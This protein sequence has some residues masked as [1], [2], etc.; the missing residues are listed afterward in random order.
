MKLNLIALAGLVGLSS[1]GRVHRASMKRV[2]FGEQLKH[3]DMEQYVHNV[4]QKYIAA[5]NRMMADQEMSMQSNGGINDLSGGHALPIENFL[6]AQYYSEISIG[7]PPQTFKVV[8]DTGSA[9]LWVPSKK[10]NSIACYLHSTYD[11][12]ASSTH[13]KNETEFKIEYGS[14]ALS[15]F[16]SQDTVRLGDVEI[17]KQ[18]FAE[19]VSEPGLAFAFGRFDGILGLAYDTISVNKIVPPFYH[20]VN[21]KLVDEPVFSFYLADKD[22]EGSGSEVVFGGVDES[23]YSG[24]LIK[25]PVR[26]KAYWE[27]KLDS[28]SF[29]DETAKLGNAGAVLDT[30]TSLLVIPTTYADMLNDKIGAEKSFNGQFKVDC[31]ARD[32]LPNITFKLA[33]HDFVLSPY[34]YILEIQGSCISGFMGMDFPEPVG[35]L[36]ILGD[37]FLRKYYS[38]YDLGSNTVSLAE[39]RH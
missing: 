6:N 5:A 13:Q 31:A 21:Q 27:V 26:R 24:D 35:P 10:C 12:G 18:D 37:I 33:G 11:S 17:E 32:S 3:V 1:A 28:M 14:G 19:A 2:P 34:E 20:M 25:L 29:G 23:R 39:A 16:I 36:F 9:N 8:L 15:G 22:A 30:G 38:V 4:N 7:N